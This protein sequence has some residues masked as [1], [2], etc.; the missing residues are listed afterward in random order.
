M[1][2]TLFP[3]YDA[4]L[5]EQI[6]QVPTFLSAEENYDSMQTILFVAGAIAALHLCLLYTMK[7][8]MGKSAKDEEG[9]RSAWKASYQLTNLLVNLSFGCLGIYYQI[10]HIPWSESIANKIAGYTDVKIFS[11][12]QVGYQL[13]ALWIGICFVDETKTMLVHHV[14][15]ICVASCSAFPT[16]GFRY[17]TPYFYGLIEISSVPLSIMNWFKNNNEWIKAYPRIYGAVRMTFAVSF[18]LVRVVLWTPYYWSFW[19]TESLLLYSSE[20]LSSIIILGLFNVASL[21]LTMLQYFWASKI[22]SA[23]IEGA[24]KKKDA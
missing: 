2:S 11:V 4:E 18:L 12:G 20:A 15:V 23:M 10:N 6:H 21:V 22:I 14:A 3:K 5:F 17:Y 8:Y 9:S 1:L 7:I 19:W 13:W 16:C 24:S